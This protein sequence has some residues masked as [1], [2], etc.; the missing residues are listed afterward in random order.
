MNLLTKIKSIYIVKVSLS[1]VL[2][3]SMRSLRAIAP[4]KGVKQGGFLVLLAG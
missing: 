4:L 3:T 2:M 1:G